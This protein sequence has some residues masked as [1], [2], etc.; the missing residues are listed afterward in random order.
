MVD[1]DLART[2]LTYI[3]SN[4]TLLDGKSALPLQDFLNDI[5]QQYVV[6]HALQLAI[7]AAMDLAAH[8]VAD[9]GWELPSRSG[10]V[11]SVLGERGV[12]SGDLASR[13]RTMASF[14][15][16][17]VHEYG[18]INLKTVYEIWHKSLSDLKEFSAAV[19][20]Y[21]EDDPSEHT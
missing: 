15:N 3:T 2:K 13:L 20:N 4:V 1:K 19:M 17:I 21:I 6:L 11:F 16:L 12:V 18:E 7:Q 14:R 5:E 10:Q 8:F 9:E